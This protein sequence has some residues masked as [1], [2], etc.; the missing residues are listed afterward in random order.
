[1]LSSILQAIDS[2]FPTKSELTRVN[3]RE[4]QIP[5]P[6][7][8]NAM[9]PLEGSG[10]SAQSMVGPGSTIHCP[11]CQKLRKQFF[12]EYNK[13][14]LHFANHS[15]DTQAGKE[16]GKVSLRYMGYA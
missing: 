6:N 12:R 8:T 13:Y 3:L 14:I 4:A 16:G 2:Y 5:R 7:R 10:V 1:M 15:L 9:V 11:P